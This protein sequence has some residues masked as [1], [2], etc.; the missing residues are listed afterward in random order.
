MVLRGEKEGADITCSSTK[1][2]I[3]SPS[4]NNGIINV[5]LVKVKLGPKQQIVSNS[6]VVFT[7]IEHFLVPPIERGIN[8]SLVALK[9]IK[10]CNN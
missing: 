7:N 6:T 4:L 9:L 10:I 3:T 1:T 2:T 8:I 5:I